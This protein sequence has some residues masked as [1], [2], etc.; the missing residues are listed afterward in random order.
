LG[1]AKL[2][3][4]LKKKIPILINEHHTSVAV[5]AWSVLL[6]DDNELRQKKIRTELG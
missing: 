4:E 2:V 3:Y 1:E 6:L 5:V